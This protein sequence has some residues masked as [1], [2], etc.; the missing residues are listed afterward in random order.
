MWQKISVFL[1]GLTRRLA[2]A[3]PR[4]ISNKPGPLA[5]KIDRYGLS[6]VGFGLIIL[7]LL[8]FGLKART[9]LL[10]ILFLLIGLR[11]TFGSKQPK[12]ILRRLRRAPRIEPE[13]ETLRK[14]TASEITTPHR[15]CRGPLLTGLILIGFGWLW[16]GAWGFYFVSIGIINLFLAGLVFLGQRKLKTEL[17]TKLDD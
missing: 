8:Q 13:I 6:L 5:Q 11:I 17:A 14:N 16:S 15:R 12:Y 4:V 10:G 2:Q 7:L 9:A 1:G 3:G